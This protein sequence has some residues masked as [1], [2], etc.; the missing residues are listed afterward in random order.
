MWWSFNWHKWINTEY[1]C[2]SEML[3]WVL[4]FNKLVNPFMN[5]WPIPLNAKEFGLS[6]VCTWWDQTKIQLSVS[7]LWKKNQVCAKTCPPLLE[8]WDPQAI[9]CSLW[10]FK[11]S[12]CTENCW[13]LSRWSWGPNEDFK[14]QLKTHH[15]FAFIEN[16]LWLPLFYRAFKWFSFF[17]SWIVLVK[18]STLSFL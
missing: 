3:T 8:S 16:L 7:M 5:S 18:F 2:M 4:W 15:G 6:A 11:A 13:F 14:S 12:F 1:S 17:P 9:C 10:K